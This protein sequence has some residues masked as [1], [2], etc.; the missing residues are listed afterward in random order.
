M[1][2]CGAITAFIVPVKYKNNVL[3]QPHTGVGSARTA[4]YNDRAV[5]P[6]IRNVCPE[7]GEL[8]N[9][10]QRTRGFSGGSATYP[11][12]RPTDGAQLRA[13]RDDGPPHQTMI[14]TGASKVPPKAALRADHASAARRAAWQLERLVSPPRHVTCVPTS[15]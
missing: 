1:L 12:G 2:I 13:A 14:P 9:L 6:H 3:T 7:C 8:P 10:Q 11:V 4:D 15:T 5:V